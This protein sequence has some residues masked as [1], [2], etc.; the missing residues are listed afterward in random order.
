VVLQRGSK[1]DAAVATDGHV[2]VA[3]DTRI[4]D[5]LLR[6]GI[7][8][9]LVSLLQ[10]ARKEA[11]LDIADRIAVSWQCSDPV[12]STALR[13]HADVIAK[14]VLALEFAEGEGAVRLEINKVPVTVTLS[15]RP[16]P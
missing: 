15:K 1:G 16:R 3:L 8:R 7:A 13:E 11:G 14:E 10:N 9:E 6:E 4:D 5:A 12:V 2:T